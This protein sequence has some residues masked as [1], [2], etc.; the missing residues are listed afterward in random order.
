MLKKIFIA[1]GGT[2]GHIIP[3]RTLA[4][5]LQ[6]NNYNITL[7]GDKKINSYIKDDDNFKTIIIKATKFEKSLG[8]LISFFI[9]F[10]FGFIKS[11][12]FIIV[13]R[14][15]FVL[16][17]GGYA[18]FPMIFAAIITR[19]KIIIHEQNAH[20]G[21][22]NRIF[23]KYATAIATSFAQT[24]GIK[25]EFLPKVVFTGNPVRQEIVSLFNQEYIIPNFP[26]DNLS[27]KFGYDV[28]LNSEFYPKDDDENLFKILVI[29]GSGGAKIFSE[30]L[31]KVFFN[32]NE[33]LKEH[34][35]ITQQCRQELVES[36]FNEYKKYNIN[37][38]VDNFF[39]DMAKIISESHL[40]IARSG[41]SSISEFCCAKKP[42]ILVPFAKSADDHQLKNAKILE[43]NGAAIVI[44]ESDFNI[45]NISEILSKLFD[46]HDILYKLSKNAEKFAITDSSSRILTLINKKI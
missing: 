15:Q 25:T 13:Q 12:F 22:V 37:I 3:A 46:Q 42:M 8:A 1:S 11:I 26:E 19:R 39:E 9:N 20:L 44:K 43:E 23:A 40:I 24:D 14:P 28:I 7:F 27:N 16:G 6:E 4:K 17:F 29:G 21:K 36:T 38:I 41:S 5:F 31:P 34:I 45:K 32:F 2:G 10:I 35:Q 18:T 30:I 33:N